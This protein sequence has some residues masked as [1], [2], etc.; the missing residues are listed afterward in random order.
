MKPLAHDTGIALHGS[1]NSPLLRALREQSRK[2]GA[3]RQ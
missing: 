3:E 2:M 1:S